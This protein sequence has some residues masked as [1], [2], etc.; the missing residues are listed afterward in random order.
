MRAFIAQLQTD[1]DR[2]SSSDEA[3]RS[4]QQW[5]ATYPEL[6]ARDIQHLLE[7]RLNPS[8]AGGILRALAVLA[9]EDRLAARALLQAMLP[10][11]IKL[12]KTAGHGDQESLEEMVALAWERIRTYPTSRQGSVAGNV[13]LDVRK[14]YWHDRKLQA[15]IA[16]P[17][18][19]EHVAG[20]SV[21]AAEELAVSRLEFA[22]TLRVAGRVVS[23]PAVRLVVSTRVA[24]I[25]L[26]EIA[27]QEGLSARALAMRRLRAERVIRRRMAG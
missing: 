5:S 26:A 9:P 11:L 22:E 2:I 8:E 16:G 4:L 10:G 7:M 3:R 21:P 14:R 19:I 23:R 17:Q 12:A 24:G 25:P 18:E 20:A 1:W 13:L 6:V 27:R 15:V